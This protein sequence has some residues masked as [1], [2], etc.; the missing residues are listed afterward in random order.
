V[1]IEVVLFYHPVVHWISR[2]V[3]NV[4]ENCCDDWY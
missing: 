4:R 3:R 1:V 2:D